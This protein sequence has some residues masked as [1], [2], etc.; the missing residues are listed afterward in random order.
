[1]KLVQLL[2]EIKIMAPSRVL[3]NLMPSSS[4]ENIMELIK[5]NKKGSF[6]GLVK[7]KILNIDKIYK[8]HV[9]FSND[10]PELVIEI[11]TPNFP[12]DHFNELVEELKKA[13]IRYQTYKIY[14]DRI[15]MYFEKKPNQFKY[16]SI[17]G[18]RLNKY[19]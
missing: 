12:R 7:I 18:D 17:N 10:F 6:M 15:T 2:N 8:A 14:D 9:S 19:I 4:S 1:M 5:G 3:I 11:D 13:G 16:I